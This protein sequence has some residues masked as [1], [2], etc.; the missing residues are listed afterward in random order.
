MCSAISWHLGY[1]IPGET[2]LTRAYK[3]QYGGKDVDGMELAINAR[4]REW[5]C[6]IDQSWVSLPGETKKFDIGRSI[7]FLTTDVI[8]HLCFGKPLGFVENQRDMHDFLKTLESRLPV[9]EQFSVLT[10]FNSLLLT[11]SNI[12]WVKKLLIP[13]AADHSGVGRILGVCRSSFM[14][15]ISKATYKSEI[16][17]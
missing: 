11:L 4:L 14:L 12:D 1:E 8:S 17:T 7:Q 2:L 5:I 9:V 15:P 6:V 13:S 3:S 10:E 16:L